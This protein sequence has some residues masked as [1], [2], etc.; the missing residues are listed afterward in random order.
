MKPT[1]ETMVTY[2][3]GHREVKS[4]YAL[5]IFR[6]SEVRIMSRNRNRGLQKMSILYRDSRDPTKCG[7]QRRAHPPQEILENAESA[8]IL[9]IPPVKRPLS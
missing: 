3:L 2:D 9:E 7:K 5:S 6:S 1:I 8:E 4:I